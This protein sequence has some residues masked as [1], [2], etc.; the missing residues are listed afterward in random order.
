[1]RFAY[2]RYSCANARRS[3]AL[4]AISRARSVASSAVARSKLCTFMVSAP[5]L[6]QR[7]LRDPAVDWLKPV[8]FFWRRGRLSDQSGG[9]VTQ[10][11]I[12]YQA[13][14]SGALDHL[15][16]LVYD[17]LQ[18]LA[19]RHI[20]KERRNHTLQSTALVHEAYLRLV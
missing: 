5:R 4:T 12:R 18:R 17:E 10:L 8:G 9:P 15:L 13:G 2:R 3:V 14:D 20:R 11:L 1:M 16:P 19:R 7:V 6:S